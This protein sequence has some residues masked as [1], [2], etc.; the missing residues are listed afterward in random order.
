MCGRTRISLENCE[1]R[2]KL[3]CGKC[4]GFT[5]SRVERMTFLQH[6]VLSFF[7]MRQLQVTSLPKQGPQ[8]RI[9]THPFVHTQ[10]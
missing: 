2:K 4:H 9:V 7:V 8:N 3:C 5:L 1:P 10:G 6:Y